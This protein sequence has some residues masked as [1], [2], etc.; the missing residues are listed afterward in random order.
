MN[1]DMHLTD[2]A[3]RIA[4]LNR[5]LVLDTPQE[6]QFEKITS[7]VCAVLDVPIAAVSLIDV[8]RQWFKSIKGLDCAETARDVS[9]C[10][11]TIKT[12]STLNVGDAERDPRF[13]NNP[14]VTGDPHIRAYLGSPLMTADGYN[15]GALCAIDRRPR[16]F[17]PQQEK[18][19]ATFAALV[20]DELELRLIAH[21]DA[22]TGAMSR[23]AFLER[24]TM[25]LSGQVPGPSTLAIM[26]ID[27]FKSI[28]DDYGH[29]AGD[30]V[31]KAVVAACQSRLR[32]G[33]CFG[34]LGGE[35]FGILFA[36]CD[37]S[38]AHAAAEQLRTS[39][40]EIVFDFEPALQ[41]TASFGL[42]ELHRGSI[43]LAM[44]EAD[45]ALYMA[46]RQGRNRCS[47]IGRIDRSI[48]MPRQ[49]MQLSA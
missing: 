6:E 34:R 2:E 30:V 21:C 32:P 17:M 28:N 44:G 35:E 11:H 22:L 36:S 16:D 7:L 23:R 19:L 31:L 14:L 10:T 13:A 1:Q 47:S 24:L 15:I 27:F 39:I 40:A 43:E 29:P 42:A 9:F 20:V 49:P 3:G 48:A 5:L 37:V 33:D 25:S 4:A 45:A 26:D 38:A 41:V 12:R 8:D 46:K 18:M